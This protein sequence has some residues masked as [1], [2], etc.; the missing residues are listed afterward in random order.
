MWGQESGKRMVLEIPLMQAGYSGYS[1]VG[2]DLL[3]APESLPSSGPLVL[4]F[5]LYRGYFS[6]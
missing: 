2:L 5:V 1:A 4:C 6:L 3:I